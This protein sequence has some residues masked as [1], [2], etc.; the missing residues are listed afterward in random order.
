MADHSLNR[1]SKAHRVAA[2]LRT[3]G[4]TPEL[5]DEIDAHHFDSWARAAGE[6]DD[7]IA[8]RGF[9]T[10]AP[11]TVDVVRALLLPDEPL[12]DITRHVTNRINASMGF[13]PVD[14]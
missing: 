5:A 3:A 9:R 11:A 13:V 1:A 2:I 14:L 6:L 10:M 7:V 8:G 12:V 4:V